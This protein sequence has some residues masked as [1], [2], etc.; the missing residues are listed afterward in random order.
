MGNP[1]KN[2]PKESLHNF[3][4]RQKLKSCNF[5]AGSLKIHKAQ[6]LWERTKW[7]KWKWVFPGR[8]NHAPKDRIS[9]K[10]SCSPGNNSA[11]PSEHLIHSHSASQAFPRNTGL[12]QQSPTLPQ[13]YFHWSK[14]PLIWAVGQ[15]RPN[16]EN[17]ERKQRY[18]TFP[19]VLIEFSPL[20]K[21][22]P[23]P[24]VPSRSCS[25]WPIKKMCNPCS[26]GT[27]DSLVLVACLEKNTSTTDPLRCSWSFTHESLKA[28]WDMVTS[29]F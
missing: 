27:G 26:R 28:N 2:H 3:N 24:S 4:R 9:I 29:P 20:F 5:A 16:S 18:I 8:W 7:R 19:N 14:Q 23:V 1:V 25:Y 6:T 22:N 13:L 10:L 15:Q 12:F 11:L 17:L 21:T